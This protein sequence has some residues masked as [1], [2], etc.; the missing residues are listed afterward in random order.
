MEAKNEKK[1][2]FL[3]KNNNKIKPKP[4]KKLNF[5]EE[6]F[7]NTKPK[8]TIKG[9]FRYIENYPKVYK[10]YVKQRWEKRGILEVFAKEFRAENEEYYVKF[11]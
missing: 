3:S 7:L 10:S 5:E 4:E 1:E 8:I 2:N 6:F 9:P 11:S